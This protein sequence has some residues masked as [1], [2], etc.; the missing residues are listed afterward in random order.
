MKL[1]F[2]ITLGLAATL[3]LGACSDV[4][5]VQKNSP[6][7]PYKDYTGENRA[8][9]GVGSPIDEQQAKANA[10]IQLTGQY[11]LEDAMRMM[12][13][14]YNLAVRW[15]ESVRKRN[16]ADLVIADL[17]F[18]EARS[19]IEDVYNI[20]IIREGERRLLIMPSRSAPRILE[21]TPGV[22]VSLSQVVRGLAEQCKFNLVITE[23]RSKLSKTRITTSFKDV[24]CLDAFEA[25]LSPQGLSLVDEGGHYTIGGFPQRQ[26]VLDLYEP[27]R[28]ETQTITYTSGIGSQGESGVSSESGGAAST[29]VTGE[30][31][32]W[33]ELE[34]DL[35]SLVE[36]ACDQNITQAEL[37]E[38]S[39]E[40]EGFAPADTNEQA[41][42]GYVRI[43]RAVGLVQMR[44]PQYILNEADEIIR[45]VEDIASRRLLVEARIVAVTRTRDFEQGGSVAQTNN[46]AGVDA[47]FDF[48]SPTVDATTSLTGKL[49]RLANGKAGAFGVK[50]EH[51]D[52]AVRVLE[53]YGTTY[54]LMQPTLEVMD[55]QRSILIDGTN[56]RYVERAL[57][58]DFDESGNRQ[59]T[60]E[61]EIKSQFVGIQFSVVAQI[62][63]AGEPHT[64]A[65][66][67][68][69]T[70]I[71]G[72]I[73]VPIST[74]ANGPV[75]EIP[76]ATT[77]LID[78]KV[79]LRD[80]EIKV[81]GGLTKT[82][83][84]D[85]ESGV[86]LLRGIPV[87][88]KLLNEEDIEYENVEFVVLLRVKRIY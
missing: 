28:S 56:Q 17:T 42:C 81:I 54:Q 65:V 15:G 22:N 36:R 16:R 45:R 27:N 1:N 40:G 31:D 46:I 67:I 33:A 87:A 21:F 53:S 60:L 79:R 4:S 3:M 57:E 83:A 43:N 82:I 50:G 12:A 70:D 14:T 69:I 64:V 13:N 19:Y 75:D 71:D 30:R 48:Q 59:E 58:V 52:A 63:D 47:G 61:T 35:T 10:T 2:G 24:D 39:E 49:L 9:L 62:A 37:L 51:L 85:K 8:I 73:N 80:G 7:T 34:G 77:R 84:V 88:G 41:G 32:L 78:Q 11:A 68:P 55:R 18:D 72:V 66:Q 29:N 44:A 26:W 38:G 5:Y 86:P 6:G 23:N 25:V 76:I 20:Q 74:E